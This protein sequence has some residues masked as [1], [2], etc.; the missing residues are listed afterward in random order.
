[1]ILLSTILGLNAN[2]FQY[3]SFCFAAFVFIPPEHHFVVSILHFVSYRSSPRLCSII[4][5]R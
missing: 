2:A 5:D 4:N 3:F 1:M